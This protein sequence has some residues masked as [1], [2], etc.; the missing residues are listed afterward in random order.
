MVAREDFQLPTL[1]RR[2]LESLE[3]G[4]REM[5]LAVRDEFGDNIKTENRLIVD[6]NEEGKTVWLQ[7]YM[8]SRHPIKQNRLS[9]MAYAIRVLT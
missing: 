2:I 6:E 7:H 3:R 1:G 5:L 9:K 8:M 4:K